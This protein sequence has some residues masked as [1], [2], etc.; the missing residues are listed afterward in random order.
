MGDPLECEWCIFK[1]WQKNYEQHWPKEWSLLSSVHCKWG[2]ISIQVLFCKTQGNVR[3]YRILTFYQFQPFFTL[4]IVFIII[5][6]SI[7]QIGCSI[8]L[9]LTTHSEGKMN[10]S[11]PL[12]ITLLQSNSTKFIHS[13][14][15]LLWFKNLKW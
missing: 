13:Y 7:K 11:Y 14:V 15:F 2:S 5:S 4:G 9:S 10:K 8:F 3:P 1:L 6:S 12:P